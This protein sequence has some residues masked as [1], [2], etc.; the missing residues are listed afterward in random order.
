MTDRVAMAGFSFA[1]AVI[2]AAGAGGL[3][4]RIVPPIVLCLYF[5]LGAYILAILLST[6]G[7]VEQI[8]S[9]WNRLM[10]IQLIAPIGVLLALALRAAW[11]A[12]FAAFGAATSPGLTGAV[13]PRRATRARG[14]PKGLLVFLGFAVLPIV[15]TWLWASHLREHARSLEALP[16]SSVAMP[17]PT[18]SRWR[19]DASLI[20]SLD[21]PAEG[22]TVH[23]QLEVR[24]WARIPGENLR[25]TLTIDRKE[26]FF[27]AGARVPRPDVEVAVPTLGDCRAAGYEAAYTFEAGDAGVHEIQVVFRTHDGRERHYPPRWFIWGP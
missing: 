13:P 20:G 24:G 7:G 3:R 19:E 9:T 16:S 18:D 14:F 1:G 22:S 21:E 5:C 23:G 27:V 6:W 11:R 26:R 8:H 10:M 25:V 17:A 12:R 2:L 15:S 4:R